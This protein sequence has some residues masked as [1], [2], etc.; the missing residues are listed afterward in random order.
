MKPPEISSHYAND[1]ARHYIFAR[2]A[3]PPWYPEKKNYDGVV[4][5][6][7]VALALIGWAFTL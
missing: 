3:D 2:R 5:V 4:L 6:V 1:D 7:T